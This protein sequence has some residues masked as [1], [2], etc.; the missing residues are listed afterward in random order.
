MEKTAAESYDGN[1]E[2]DTLDEDEDHAIK[3]TT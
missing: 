3:T 1:D 2:D